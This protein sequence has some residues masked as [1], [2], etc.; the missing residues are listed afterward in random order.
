MSPNEQSAFDY[1]TIVSIKFMVAD[2][3]S[4][5]SRENASGDQKDATA[6]LDS[7][8]ARLAFPRKRLQQRP[9]EPLKSPLPP[10]PPLFASSQ[11]YL[12][13]LSPICFSPRRV[14]GGLRRR[15]RTGAV[16]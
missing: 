3:L 4:S 10:N 8:L 2:L 12:R 16:K 7:V 11:L 14:A 13:S 1:R 6:R 5:V 15:Y 9:P